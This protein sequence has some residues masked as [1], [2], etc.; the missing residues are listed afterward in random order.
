VRPRF[1][2]RVSAP[3]HTE[4]SNKKTVTLSHRRYAYLRPAIY[5]CGDNSIQEHCYG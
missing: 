1:K 5:D 4:R 3:S 2:L